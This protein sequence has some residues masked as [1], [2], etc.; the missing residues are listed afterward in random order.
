MTKEIE[1]LFKKMVLRDVEIKINDRKLND[2]VIEDFI[3]IEIL[4]E[5]EDE[6]T[7]EK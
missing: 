7:K 5:L 2:F 6:Y 4:R 1:N 3:V